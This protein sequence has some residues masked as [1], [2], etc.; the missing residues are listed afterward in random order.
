MPHV[1]VANKDDARRAKTFD[2][3]RARVRGDE[4]KRAMYLFNKN[5]YESIA[6]SEIRDE[7]SHVLACIRSSLDN[8]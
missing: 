4:G 2:V 7:T 3:K 1:T 6:R 5:D 8:I